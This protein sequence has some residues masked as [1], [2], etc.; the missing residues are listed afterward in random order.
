M[1][2]AAGGQWAGECDDIP[3]RRSLITG[4]TS[5]AE[6]FQSKVDDYLSFQG[7]PGLNTQLIQA[8]FGTFGEL[9]VIAVSLSDCYI[10][11]DP[12]NGNLSGP[13]Q[14]G[15][16]LDARGL[17][18]MHSGVFEAGASVVY[19]NS[20]GCVANTI[21][22]WVPAPGPAGTIP[23]GFTPVTTPSNPIPG[24]PSNWNCTSDAAGTCTCILEYK[25]EWTGPGPC[26]GPTWTPPMHSARCLVIERW[27][28]TSTGLNCPSASCPNGLPPPTTAPPPT[29]PI[30]AGCTPIIPCTSQ[31]LYWTN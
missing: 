15:S 25:H 20:E 18:S 17:L 2:I 14:L 19:Y 1:L 11:M 22:V 31:I 5:T 24:A 28:C 30:G 7:N 16:P 12:T 3:Q 10:L 6:K 13:F 4:E 8:N 23:A 21:G 9:P 26:P 29:N 27:T